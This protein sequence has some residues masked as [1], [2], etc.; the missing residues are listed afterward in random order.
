MKFRFS[1]EPVLR[2]REHKE[3]IQQQKLAEKQRIKQ[4]LDER[5]S[6]IADE[7]KQFLGEKEK[8][9]V[10]DIRKLRNAYAHMEHTHQM[11]GK[12][13]RDAGKAQDEVNR[14]RDKLLKA[15]RETHI[16]EKI[17]D[18][19]HSAFREEADRMEQKHMDEIAAQ[20]FGR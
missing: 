8:A 18:R 16:L 15:H 20:Y 7:L 5:K 1:L 13:D 17:K 6:E 10:Y 9:S 19:E 14:E 4:I 11:M 2:V 3:K 12:I